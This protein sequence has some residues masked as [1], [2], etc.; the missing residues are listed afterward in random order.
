M[1]NTTWQQKIAALRGRVMKRLVEEV[2]TAFARHHN[3]ILSGQLK[4][5]FIAI[6]QCRY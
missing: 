4:R 5:Q 6:L 2:T 3:E 1:T